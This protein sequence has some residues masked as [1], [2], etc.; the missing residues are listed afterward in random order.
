MKK[1]FI[2]YLIGTIIIVLVATFFYV[3]Y[4]QNLPEFALGSLAQLPSPRTS[5]RVLVIA[6][7]PDDET[8]GVGGYIAQAAASGATVKVVIITNGDG[9][10]FAA[11]DKFKNLYPNQKDY[12]SLGYSRQNESIVALAE[13]GLSKSNVIFLGFPDSGLKKLLT[14]NWQVPYKSTYTKTNISPYTDSYEPDISYTGE[15]LIKDLTNIV[16]D[17]KPTIVFTTSSTDLHPDH[18]AVATFTRMALKNQTN[19]LLYFYLIH[20]RHFPSPKGLNLSRYLTPPLRLMNFDK[21]WLNYNLNPNT[22]TLKENAISKYKSQFSDPLLKSLM[23]G[24]TKKNEIFTN[25]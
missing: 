4:F 16:S 20:Y 21:T 18:A 17:Y 15:N 1:K 25:F 24:F 11:S 3:R 2:F 9:G 22:E 13:L 19:Y 7:H 10:R 6:P 5:D 8:L 12:I 14:R 23:F